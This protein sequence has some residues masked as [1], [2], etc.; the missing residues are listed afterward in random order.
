MGE[1]KEIEEGWLEIAHATI[2][3]IDILAGVVS[4]KYTAPIRLPEPAE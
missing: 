4:I 3:A 1:W 2:L